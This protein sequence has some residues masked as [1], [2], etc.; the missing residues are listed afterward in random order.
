MYLSKR[1]RRMEVESRVPFGVKFVQLGWN[2]C[3]PPVKP[4][5]SLRTE[6]RKSDER[7]IQVKS[8][9]LDSDGIRSHMRFGE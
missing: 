7:P 2:A 9:H 4:D 5:W 1:I 6:A 8:G 3:T